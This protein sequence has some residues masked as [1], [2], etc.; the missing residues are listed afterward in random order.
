MILDSTPTKICQRNIT[1]VDVD[2]MTRP[3][4]RD[5]LIGRPRIIGPRKA[6]LGEEVRTSL[7]TERSTREASDPRSKMKSTHGSLGLNFSSA[8]LAPIV[9]HYVT[10]P[11][12][13]V[14]EITVRIFNYRVLR[15]K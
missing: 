4:E 9:G 5:W 1:E 11:V 13:L 14:I 10:D 2:C 15:E 8:F 3:S 12:R 7:K 6:S